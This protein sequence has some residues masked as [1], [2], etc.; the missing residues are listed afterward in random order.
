MSENDIIDKMNACTHL[1]VRELSEPAEHSLRVVIDEA[2]VE[3]PLLN[4]NIGNVVLSGVRE[5]Q[6]S[7]N[8]FSFELVWPFYVTYAVT[9][10]SYAV[11]DE[12][13]LGEGK[14]FRIYS[15]SQFLDYAKIST[16]QLGPVQH[17]AVYSLNSTVNVVAHDP[18]QLRILSPP[19]ICSNK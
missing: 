6:T 15:K 18:P 2:R 3:G 7:P 19:P 14:L 1:S 13:A 4:L 9:P 11:P 16:L 17:W 10:E 8:N 12:S 5:I